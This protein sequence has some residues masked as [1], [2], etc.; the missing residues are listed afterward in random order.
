[1]RRVFFLLFF[2]F[3][4][5]S[6]EKEYYTTIPKFPVNLK[7]NLDDMKDL[8]AG[9]SCKIFTKPRLDSDRLGYGGILVINGGDY[10]IN[11]FAYDLACPVEAQPNIRVTPDAKNSNITATCAKCGAVFSIASGYGNPQSGTRYSLRR[12][13][14]FRDGMQ[15]VVT[16]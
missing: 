13:N 16:N 15:Y 1:M 8:N 9:L 12:Y 10:P 2:V 14:V 6:C 11:L 4:A 7:L 3:V 5:F